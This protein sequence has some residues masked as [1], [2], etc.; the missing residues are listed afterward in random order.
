MTQNIV[1]FINRDLRA[2]V[3]GNLAEDGDISRFWLQPCDA[4]DPNY[5]QLSEEGLNA[6]TNSSLENYL[7]IDGV[8]IGTLNYNGTGTITAYSNDRLTYNLAPEDFG[9]ENADLHFIQ[10]AKFAATA[11]VQFNSPI[12]LRV[13]NEKIFDE[14]LLG[15][16]PPILTFTVSADEVGEHPLASYVRVML[17]IEQ[18][19]AFVRDLKDGIISLAKI[20]PKEQHDW[21]FNQLYSVIRSRK[22]ENVFLGLYKILE[23]FFPLQNVLELKEKI[24]FQESN[25]NLIRHCI[26]T[27]QWHIGH[28]KG[29]Q[30][31]VNFASHRFAEI[32]LDRAF[33]HKKSEDGDDNPRKEAERK[34]KIKA[35][36]YL[37]NIRHDLTHQNFSYKS[38]DS[39]EMIRC[40]QALISYLTEAFS[41]YSATI[42]KA[43][44]PPE[45]VPL[46]AEQAPQD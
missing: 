33:T 40:C 44:S 3:Q 4:E 1:T 43:S 13:A 38:Y 15:Y 26:E 45:Q 23:F 12:P 14:D 20:I 27:L 25:L 22:V 37:S 30:S 2:L 11:R 16:F 21:L 6:F 39:D 28:Y 8:K 5:A 41:Q 9:L 32:G 24:S 31:S 10:L 29:A 19:K 36:D 17:F 42:T 7:D 18:D 46:A 34:F 35:M